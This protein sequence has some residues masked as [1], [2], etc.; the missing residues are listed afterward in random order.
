MFKS[1]GNDEPFPGDSDEENARVISFD[2]ASIKGGA[3]LYPTRLASTGAALQYLAIGPPLLDL[4]STFKNRTLFELVK[5]FII[6]AE[7]SSGLSV[8]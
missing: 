4:V 7:A 1:E 3:W 5:V 8:G 2:D 6:V